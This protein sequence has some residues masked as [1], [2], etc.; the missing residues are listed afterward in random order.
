MT[1]FRR[2][3]YGYRTRPT[4][5]SRFLRK[6]EQRVQQFT[7]ENLELQRQKKLRNPKNY[8]LEMKKIQQAER[9]K[10]KMELRK[11]A[12]QKEKKR[13]E[14][15]VQ[16]R[17][18]PTFEDLER[19]YKERLRKPKNYFEASKKIAQQL[20]DEKQEKIAREKAVLDE[21]EKRARRR[22]RPPYRAKSEQ[23]ALK[24]DFD[25]VTDVYEP[26]AIYNERK[27]KRDWDNKVAALEHEEQKI[28]EFIQKAKYRA[29]DIPEVDE[30]VRKIVGQ[31]ESRSKSSPPG[32]RIELKPFDLES[33]EYKGIE[34]R[35]EDL[36]YLTKKKIHDSRTEIA[37]LEYALAR[38][39]HMTSGG[40]LI[41]ANQA[42][43]DPNMSRFKWDRDEDEELFGSGR[44]PMRGRYVDQDVTAMDDAEWDLEEE[45]Y[46]ARRSPLERTLES[47]VYLVL[48]LIPCGTTQFYPECFVSPSYP[49]YFLCNFSRII[50]QGFGR[51]NEG[52]YK[53]VK[54]NKLIQ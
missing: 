27:A 33:Y 48:Y 30:T 4:H 45:A 6:Q 23:P 32:E 9:D 16:V 3:L 28:K 7:P 50:R 15:V 36:D 26:F 38:R 54:I 47:E 35:P 49:L 12:P 53:K 13:K 2:P 43:V 11:V 19:E 1:D 31:Q 14:E 52:S 29:D 40:R 41:K 37:E 18:Q 24:A 8:F 5:E 39:P 46:Y 42:V 21:V 34:E 17:Q 25:Y 20:E 22:R 51:N 44:T 10:P